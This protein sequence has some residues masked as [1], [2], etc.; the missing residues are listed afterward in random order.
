MKSVYLDKFTNENYRTIAEDILNSVD[1]DKYD[2]VVFK[3]DRIC[4]IM[5][6]LIVGYKGLNI[7][8]T[9][10][11]FAPWYEVLML[12]T[13]MYSAVYDKDNKYSSLFLA[14]DKYEERAKELG[15]MG[16]EQEFI[17]QAV[18]SAHGVY[19]PVKLKPMADSPHEMF[20]LAIW[21]FE[22]HFSWDKKVLA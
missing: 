2:N 17:F 8:D 7:K 13:F 22:N 12:A 1:E 10:G 20:V 11:N 5:N 15:I 4:D 14:R 19:G 9:V 18:E 6:S 21:L 16:Q 3:A